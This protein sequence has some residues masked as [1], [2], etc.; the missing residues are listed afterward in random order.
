MRRIYRTVSE[1]TGCKKDKDRCV[2]GW[3]GP[4]RRSC[5]DM[6]IIT[7]ERTRPEGDSGAVSMYVLYILLR[8]APGGKERESE[9]EVTCSRKTWAG[10]TFLIQFHHPYPTYTY[11]R[12]NRHLACKIE[13]KEPHTHPVTPRFTHLSLVRYIYTHA[14]N[15]QV[16]DE[17]RAHAFMHVRVTTRQNKQ[18][19]LHCWIVGESTG[20][21][22]N[23]YFCW[24][25]RRTRREQT[26]C[27][28]GRTDWPGQTY[29]RN[30]IY[31]Y[32]YIYVT[33]IL[34][35]HES[36]RPKSPSRPLHKLHS[37]QARPLLTGAGT[38]LQIL[39]R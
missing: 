19:F 22:R 26:R 11:A 31:T 38:P 17:N 33:H 21:K 6:S 39:Y 12:H 23:V 9:R 15:G 34:K 5:L 29:T 8:W 1:V 20:R 36:L 10:A 3:R 37:R 25:R 7:H 4:H 35:A 32:I 28:A 14:R 2:P 24:E 16:G 30:D 27:L 13:R 18:S